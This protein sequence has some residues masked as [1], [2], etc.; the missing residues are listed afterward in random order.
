MSSPAER[1][2]TE[3]PAAGGVRTSELPVAAEIAVSARGVRKEYVGGDGR[4]L[5]VLAGVDLDVARGEAV[6]VIGRSGSGK[7]TLLHV[8]GGLDLPNQGEVFVG[9][10]S[11][12]ALNEEEL[13]RV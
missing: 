12:R 6:S 1:F 9:G 2:A 7:S 13:A 11:L 4:T 5:T 10:R 3:L 8:L